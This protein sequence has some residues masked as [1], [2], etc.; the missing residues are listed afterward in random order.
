MTY[1]SNDTQKFP[2]LIEVEYWGDIYV[3]D[4]TTENNFKY[5][6]GNFSIYI[7]IR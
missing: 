1:P 5:V 7:N 4:M 3:E 6:E 2:P